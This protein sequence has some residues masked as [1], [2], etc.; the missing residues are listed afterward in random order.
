MAN[1]DAT[2]QL[3]EASLEDMDELSDMYALCNEKDDFWQALVGMMKPDD[4]RVLRLTPQRIEGERPG[5]G[6]AKITE[7]ANGKS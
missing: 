7:I 5:K 6:I 3:S 1:N 4:H 2:F